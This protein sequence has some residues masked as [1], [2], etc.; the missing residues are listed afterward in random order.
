MTDLATAAALAALRYWASQA[1]AGEAVWDSP[2]QHESVRQAA[3]LVKG[4]PAAGDGWP[5]IDLSQPLQSIFSRITP[6]VE[7][8]QAPDIYIRRAS[9][10]MSEQALFPVESQQASAESD[11]APIAALQHEEDL[12]SERNLPAQVHLEGLLYALQ[13]HAW[14]LPSPLDAVSLY[15]FARTH[16]AVA[17][18]RAIHDGDLFLLGGDLSGV[19]SFLYT[20]TA[21][22]ATK[23]LRGRSFYLQLLTEACAQYL[24]RAAGLPLTNLLY[25]GGGRFY[26]LLPGQ[27]AGVP[28][29]IWLA[30]QRTTLDALFLHQHQ[31]DLYPALGG[32]MLG[33]ADLLDDEQFRQAWGAATEAINKA[34]RRRFADV[35]AKLFEPQGHGGNEDAACV[36]CGYQGDP[37]DFALPEEG[38]QGRHCKLCDSFEDLGR[39]LHNAEY[40]LLH[41]LEHP[42]PQPHGRRRR[43]NEFLV[44]LGIHVQF[45]GR[46]ARLGERG[47][48]APSWP[49]RWTTALALEDRAPPLSLAEPIVF[50][51]NPVA[52]TTPTMR[53]A[54][55]RDWKPEEEGEPRPREGDVKPFS[56]MVAQSRGVKRLGV[57]RMDMDDLGDLFRYRL[58]SGLARVSALSAALALF[59]DGW[60][61]HVCDQVNEPGN[62]PE[63]RGSVYTIYSGGDDLFIVGS[64]H[65]L[66]ALARRISDDL[67]AYTGQHPSVHI[68]AGISLHGAKFPLYQAA[69]AA[70]EELKRAKNRKGKA[71]LGWLE[72]VV[73]WAYYD[74]LATMQ[75]E[76]YAAVKV[77]GA[78]HAILQTGQQFYI[79]YANGLMRDPKRRLFYGP[80]IWRGVYQLAR[81]AKSMGTR[82][83]EITA[84]VKRIREHLL[85]GTDKISG[86]GARYIERLGLAARWAQLE[87]RKEQTNGIGERRGP[88]EDHRAG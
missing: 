34:K 71:A 5:T 35:G 76:L 63:Q 64:W 27:I 8:Q 29:D 48:H 12:L 6:N 75:H 62:E 47:N 79:Q 14:C 28:A 87:L 26:A 11:A 1:G 24:L 73:A 80:W 21:A 74:A 84:L 66:P 50:G 36:V 67:A 53:A 43:W 83:E 40:L 55:M 82:D 25:A 7:G 33:E 78:P 68:S 57:L 30:T 15:D 69:E 2:E 42:E 41:H 39:L 65:L 18:A 20:L 13:R 58:D 51:F 31:G 19:Q 38:Q 45:S 61:G 85:D 72:Q 3:W 44:E 23:Q 9:L 10:A 60:V 81:V 59:F 4:K 86:E 56:V 52:N 77:N 88:E 16:A 54:D 17:A 46:H 49:V 22:G 37:Q 32:D 70:D